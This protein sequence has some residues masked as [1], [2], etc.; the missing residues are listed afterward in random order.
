VA[1]FSEASSIHFDATIA[2]DWR[3]AKNHAEKINK[4]FLEIREL[5][6]DAQTALRNLVDT[7][8]FPVA[9]MAA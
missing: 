4:S 9:A 6:T 7:E 1:D 8:P 2:G 3:S 5:G